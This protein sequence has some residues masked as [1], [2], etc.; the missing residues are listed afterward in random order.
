MITLKSVAKEYKKR[1]KMNDENENSTTNI[2]NNLANLN[3]KTMAVLQNDYLLCLAVSKRETLF[4][5]FN[6]HL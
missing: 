3:F 5:F 4:S 6:D 1:F 2:K